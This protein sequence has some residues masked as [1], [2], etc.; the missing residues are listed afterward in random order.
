ML[1][2]NFL[3]CARAEIKDLTVCIV[4][5]GEKFLDLDLY[6]T[7]CQTRPSYFH[8]LH[9]VVDFK[10]TEPL[11]FEL[12]THIQ[13]HRRTHSP[14]QLR[15]INRNYNYIYGMHNYLGIYVYLSLYIFMEGSQY[16]AVRIIQ[17]MGQNEHLIRNFLN[18][19]I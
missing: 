12:S 7:Q 18:S 10:W 2:H 17:Y 11:F 9:Y 14:L 1:N 16:G 6:N 8:I 15:L 13:T 19:V 3:T 4:V 5:K